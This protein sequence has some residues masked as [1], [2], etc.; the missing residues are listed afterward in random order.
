[1]AVQRKRNNGGRLPPPTAHNAFLVLEDTGGNVYVVGAGALGKPV[2][3][4]TALTQAL[5][6]FKVE[7]GGKPLLN[8]KFAALI[9]QGDAMQRLFGNAK[10]ASVRD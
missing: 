4:T 1:M 9:D 10:K 5:D 2:K 6:K 3:L 7:A 8:V